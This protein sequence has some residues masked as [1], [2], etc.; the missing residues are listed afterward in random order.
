MSKLWLGWDPTYGPVARIMANSGSDP[1]THPASDFGAFRFDSKSAAIGYG[2]VSHSYTF[3]VQSDYSFGSGTNSYYEPNPSV[4]KTRADTNKPTSTLWRLAIYA[5]PGNIWA[6]GLNAF[7]FV[8]QDASTWRQV[9]TSFGAAY[10]GSSD[11]YNITRRGIGNQYHEML[12]P[13]RTSGAWSAAAYGYL[14]PAST[15][16]D[17]NSPGVV[18]IEGAASQAALG[19]PKLVF[20]HMDLPV[21]ETPYPLVGP[22]TPVAGQKILRIDPASAKMAKPGYDIGWANPSQLIFDSAKRPMKVIKTGVQNIG[23]GGVVG[24]PLGAPYDTSIFVDYLV[25]RQDLGHVWLPAWPD[26]PAHFF[27]VLY[28][29]NGAMLELYNTSTLP[30]SVRYVVMA[31]DDLSA[32]VGTA[33]VFESGPGYALSRVPGAAGTRLKDTILDSRLAYLPV[34]QQAWVPFGAFAGSGIPE[35]THQYSVGWANPGNWKPY[36]LAKVARQHKTTGQ[37]VYQDFFAKY[38]SQYSFFSDSSFMCRLTDTGATFYANNGTRFEDAYRRDPPAGQQHR[39]SSYTT[40]GIRY[41]VF[42][43]P[44][45][46]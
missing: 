6:G 32:S 2:D 10:S 43:I 39:S 21:D 37:I 29:I 9:W 26:N 34:V 41:Y 33:K 36:V 11:T 35:F 7:Y 44:T 25:Q 24:V 13:V 18:M 38:I 42:A 3:P 31:A 12:V 27:N 40:I 46:L 4:P 5:Y 45:T 15:W 17:I 1:L 30:V 14:N 8:A 23:Q 19:T 16:T 28:R 22:G 20:Y